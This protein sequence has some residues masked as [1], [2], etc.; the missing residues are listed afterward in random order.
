M[1]EHP[2]NSPAITSERCKLLLSLTDVQKVRI[3]IGRPVPEAG[4]VAGIE[5]Q[6]VRAHLTPEENQLLWS[7]M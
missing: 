4:E 5:R 3:L 1:N 2:E 7:C 6:F